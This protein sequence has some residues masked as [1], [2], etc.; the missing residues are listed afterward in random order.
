MAMFDPTDENKCK[1]ASCR[2]EIEFGE[3]YCSDECRNAFSS[4]ECPCGHRHCK[5]DDTD[6]SSI[7]SRELV[8]IG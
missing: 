1:Q 3:L 6:R 2:C 4:D 5:Q 7:R 8:T